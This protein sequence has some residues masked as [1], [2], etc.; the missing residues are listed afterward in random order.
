MNIQMKEAVFRV[1]LPSNEERFVWHPFE[2]KDT[3]PNGTFQGYASTFGGDP[4]S[5]GHVIV[6]GAFKKTLAKGGRNRT[7][8]AM[9]FAHDVHS[10]IGRWTELHE[11]SKGLWVEGR[12][13]MGTNKGREVFELLRDGALQHMSIGFDFPRDEQ[14]NIKA[15]AI[16]QANGVTYLKELELWE[17]SLV[18]FPANIGAVVTRVK[19]D[20]CK[21]FGLDTPGIS[22]ADLPEVREAARLCAINSFSK[23]YRQVFR[24]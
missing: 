14:G 4:D 18:T 22:L 20:S 13:S 12:L 16:E 11:D 6:E 23:V 19:S 10:P 5:H 7:G 15:G 9:L 21:S 17:I 1:D 3:A 2:I 8:I 24:L